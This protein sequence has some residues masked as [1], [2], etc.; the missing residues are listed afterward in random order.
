MFKMP[1]NLPTNIVKYNILS[2]LLILTLLLGSFNLLLLCLLLTSRKVVVEV[3][4]ITGQLSLSVMKSL[5]TS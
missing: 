3:I 2:Y 4:F 5:Q 1:L